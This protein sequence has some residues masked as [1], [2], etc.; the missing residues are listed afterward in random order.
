MEIFADYN[1]MV[2]QLGYICFFSMVFPLT[3]LLAFANNVLEIRTDA[4]KLCYGMQRPEARRAESIGTWLTIIEIMAFVSANAS[5]GY[6]FF[7]MKYARENFAVESRIWGF[8]LLQNFLILFRMLTPLLVPEMTEETRVRLE[9]SVTKKRHLLHEQFISAIKHTHGNKF[10]RVM[11]AYAFSEKEKPQIQEF[12]EFS[13]VKY[14]TNYGKSMV[15]NYEIEGRP[16][17]FETQIVPGSQT[18][19]P[20]FCLNKEPSMWTQHRAKGIRTEAPAP[21][22]P[23]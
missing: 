18:C 3:P 17:K 21:K 19:D 12:P 16:L 7:I 20:Y 6:F 10:T 13:A 5:A 22:F 14:Y 4:T 8:F 15:R 9:V 11:T 2:I 1:E 23:L